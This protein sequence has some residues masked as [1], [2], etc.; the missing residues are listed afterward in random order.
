MYYPAF[1][2]FKELAKKGNLIPIYKEILAD[3]ETPVSALLKL[4]S[5]PHVFLLESVEG[6]EKWGRYTFLG[7]DSHVIFKVKGEDVLIQKDGEISSHKH[8]GDPM[9]FLKDLLHIYRPVPLDGLPRFYGGAVGF[10]GYDMVRYFERLP[11]EAIEDLMT[12]DATFLITDTLMI[13]DNVRHTIKVVACVLTEGR[14][15]LGAV[16]GEAVNKID[17]MIE[18]LRAPVEKG[19]F[20]GEAGYDATPQSNM[21]PE[22]FNAMVRRAKEYIVSGDVIQVVLS[23]RFEME[24]SHDPVDLYRALRYI[25][26]S[27]YLF[28]LK[29]EDLTLI[30]SSPEVMVRIE[31]G[32]AELRPIAGTRRRGKNEQEDRSLSDELLQDPKERAEHVMLVDLGRNDLGRIARIGS[33]Q[34]N[35]FMVVERYS[36][37]MH[38]VSH[39][40]AQLSSDKDAFDV[41]RATFPAGTLTGAPKIRAMEI[42]DE[43]EPSRRGPYGG[44]VGYFSFTGNID[45]CITIRTMVIKDGKIFVQAG[46]GIVADSDPEAEYQ[47]TLN[48]AMGMLQAVRMVASG[49]EITKDSD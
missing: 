9:R 14:G 31:D 6:G 23:Q 16:Y 3:M 38:L 22:N 42:I 48:K 7:S 8:R 2:T 10:L 11:A 4:R 13:F 5:K 25:N 32:V 49:L 41:L 21:M 15:D 35:Q 20:P 39:I 46:A 44:A 12:D 17:Q 40:Q 1:E 24:N 45:F 34:V 36:H 18:M 29:F 33:V 19:E 37:V 26:P 30:G 47:E 43:L 28:F 27:P